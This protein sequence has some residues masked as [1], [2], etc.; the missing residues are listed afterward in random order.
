VTGYPV[1]KPALKTA[2]SILQAM[3]IAIPV[4]TKMPLT[5]PEEFIRVDLIGG[6]RSLIVTHTARLLVEVWATSTA[7]VEQMA[8]DAI[9][10]L[11]NA[12]GTMVEG[13]FIRGFDNIEGPVNFS[14]PDVEFMSRW[15]FQGDLLV[16]TS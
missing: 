3:D 12:E 5:L 1:G 10:A 7:V 4:M 15:Q 16:S 2:V 8:F 13:V 9:G 6:T 14:D 11:Q